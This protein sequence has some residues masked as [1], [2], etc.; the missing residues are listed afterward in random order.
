MRLL[1]P[2]AVAALLIA[3]LMPAASG[4]DAAGRRAKGYSRRG[5]WPILCGPA[6]QALPFFASVSRLLPLSPS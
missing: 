2:L 4:A 6:S 1:K 5:T 3:V